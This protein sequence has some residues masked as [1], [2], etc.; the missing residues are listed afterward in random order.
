[1]MPETVAPRTDAFGRPEISDVAR[2][3]IRKAFEGIEGRDALIVIGDT[4]TR[5]VRAHLAANI[6]DKGTWKVAAGGGFD[7]GTKEPFAEFA[8]M[9]V[10]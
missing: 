5:T 10:W 8:I 4:K 6:D 3:R 1:M 9:K 7:F 2:E